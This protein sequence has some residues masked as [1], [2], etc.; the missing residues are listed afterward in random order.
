[1]NLLAAWACLPVALAKEHGWV[2]VY[3]TG[4]LRLSDVKTA[5]ITAAVT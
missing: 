5:T 1:M 4:T 3:D 2:R